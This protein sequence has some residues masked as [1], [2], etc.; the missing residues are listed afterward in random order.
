MKPLET[1]DFKRTDETG[2]IEGKSPRKMT[3]LTLHSQQSELPSKSRKS[4][5]NL[6]ESTVGEFTMELKDP[7]QV[8]E[9]ICRLEEKSLEQIYVNQK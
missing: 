2:C 9:V 8:I 6:G 4:V 7:L 5:D 3:T 1:S